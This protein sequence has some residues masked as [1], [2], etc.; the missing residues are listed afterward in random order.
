MKILKLAE[1]FELATKNLQ[2]ADKDTVIEEHEDV[3]PVSYMAAQNLH[4]LLQ[5]CEELVSL[6]ND[7]DDLPQW[8]DELLSI[9]KNNVN[10]ALSYVKGEKSKSTNNSLKVAQQRGFLSSMKGLFNKPTSNAE[11]DLIDLDEE[12]RDLYLAHGYHDSSLDFDIKSMFEAMSN[13]KWQKAKM[14]LIDFNS[15]LDDMQDK[16]SDFVDSEYYK[17]SGFMD[18]FKSKKAPESE[19]DKLLSKE[20][21]SIASQA[22][23]TLKDVKSIFSMLDKYRGSLDVASYTETLYSLRRVIM[24]FAKVF[25]KFETEYFDLIDGDMHS[26]IK[27]M[28]DPKKP[29]SFAPSKLEL[30]KP[31][32]FISPDLKGEKPSGTYWSSPLRLEPGTNCPCGSTLPWIACHGKNEDKI[33]LIMKNKGVSY[34]EA[35]QRYFK[36]V[37]MHLGKLELQ[38]ANDLEKAKQQFESIENTMGR[39][40]P[41]SD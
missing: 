21:G 39:N 29:N 22:K 7:E 27:D 26:T 9:S 4:N 41:I 25:G 36:W 28:A 30:S 13:Q 37:N 34:E 5:D 1:D 19:L 11:S 40:F 16:I 10:K 24:D 8:V 38:K 14:H 20:F 18:M 2:E 3:S 17:K 33:E 32:N 31:E 12:L 35:E 15:A 6:L 23:M